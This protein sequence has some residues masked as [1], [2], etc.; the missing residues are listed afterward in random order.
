MGREGEPHSSLGSTC[1]RSWFGVIY[2]TYLADT[3]KERFQKI[4]GI[5]HFTFE[6][7]LANQSAQETAEHA[8]KE[9]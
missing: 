9:L 2:F 7:P 5:K 6:E 3:G 8:N 4:T 1:C